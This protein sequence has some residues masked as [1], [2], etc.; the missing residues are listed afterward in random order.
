MGIYF[1]NDNDCIKLY[2]NGCTIDL[3]VECWACYSEVPIEKNNYPYDENGEC[4]ICNGTGRQ[5]T[6]NGANLLEFIKRYGNKQ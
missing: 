1:L 6:K 3:D 4:T 2:I 5:L